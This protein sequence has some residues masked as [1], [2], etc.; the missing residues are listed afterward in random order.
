MAA[1]RLEPLVLLALVCN[2]LAAWHFLPRVSRKESGVHREESWINFTRT[3][4][5][6]V[7][8]LSFKF[9]RAPH[10]MV[11]A[12]PWPPHVYIKQSLSSGALGVTG[13]MGRLMDVLAT[14]LNFT[15]SVIQ[16]DGYWGAPQADGSWNGMIGTVL[17][18][19]ADI[20]L[21]PFGMS[22][23]RSKVV[24]F[25][26]PVF[27]EMLHVLVNRPLPQ[28]DPAGFL[29]PFTWYVWVGILAGLVCV[30]ATSVIVVRLLGFGGHPDVWHHVWAF[31]SVT[32]SQN[33]PWVPKAVTSRFTFCLWMLLAVVIVR[34]YSGALTSLLAV[35]TLAVKYDSLRDVLDDTGLTLLMEGSTALTTHL[36]TVKEGVYADLARESRVRAKYVKASETYA[37]AYDLIPDGRHAML[38]EDVVCRKVYSDYFSMTGRCDF[39]MSTKSF[40]RLIYAMIVQPGSP[41]RQLLDVRIRAIREFGIYE[42]WALD[43]MPNMTHCLITPKKIKFQ[44][45]FSLADLWAVFL[46]LVGG[47]GLATLAFCSEFLLPTHLHTDHFL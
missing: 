42:R 28:P 41:L 27:L 8:P 3:A 32:V 45:P 7:R 29:A 36:Q 15:Y 14:S 33:L 19:E 47:F 17:R 21:G 22:D 12:E 16:K 24:D 1:G 6:T 43:Q 25:T 40:W 30:V 35:K 23:S 20:G 2:T 34:S 37:A 9:A 38:V 10:F 44:E 4:L 5:Q 18:Q 46:L 39:Y 26:I 31:Y 11:A 13:P